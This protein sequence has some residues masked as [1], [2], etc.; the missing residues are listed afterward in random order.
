MNND[1]KALIVKRGVLKGVATRFKNFLDSVEEESTSST[2]IEDRLKRFGTSLDR[3][4]DIHY[5]ILLIENNDIHAAEYE[6]FENSYFDHVDN[7]K[8]LIKKV[9][10]TASVPHMQNHQNQPSKI[11]FPQIKLPEFNFIFRTVN[12]PIFL[13]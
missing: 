7:A 5:Q 2:R 8:N 12:I 4:R 10:P 13:L 9:T 6:S 11:N 3:F 1:L